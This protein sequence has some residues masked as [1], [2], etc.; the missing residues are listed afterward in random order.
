MPFKT[1]I[2]SIDFL[3]KLK[4]NNNREWFNV[5]KADYEKALE[6]VTDFADALLSE[7]SIHDQIQTSS[8]KKS[9]YR[10][11]RD[12]RFSQD[13]TPYKVHWAG[14]LRRAT[15][16]LRGGY[17]FH[18]EPGDT[19]IAGGFFGPNASDLK[20]IREHIALDDQPLRQVLQNV[21]FKKY[22]GSL[23][24]SQLKTAPKGFSRDHLAIDLLR[25]KQFYLKHKF[26]DK[27]V[28]NPVF[29]QTMTQGF[30]N[31]RPFFDYMSEI[32]TTDLNGI[33]L[34]DG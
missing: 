20:H 30:N 7:M 23:Q 14:Y 17:Y 33:P 22:F 8:G 10:I 1:L 5:H 26:N 9:L 32:L 12:V 2:P 19:Y 6:N 3:K 4:S 27:E 15:K 28:L 16:L 11:Y 24:G 29:A 25:Y 21:R 31:L 34:E 13:K 18:I